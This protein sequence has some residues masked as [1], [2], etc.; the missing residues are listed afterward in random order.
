LQDFVTD[1]IGDDEAKYRTTELGVSVF[2][3]KRKNSRLAPSLPLK[4]FMKSL[5][6]S[7]HQNLQFL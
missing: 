4:E 6:N 7:I 3:Q 1:F 5:D 2:E